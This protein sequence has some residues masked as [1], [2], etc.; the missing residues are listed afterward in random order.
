MGRETKQIRVVTRKHRLGLLG[1]H[2]RIDA[3]PNRDF[4]KDHH[5]DLDVVERR[6]TSRCREISSEN[7]FGFDVNFPAV[8]FLRIGLQHREPLHRGV[9]AKDHLARL[10]DRGLRLELELLFVDFH[11]PTVR[12]QVDVGRDGLEPDRLVTCNLREDR[13]RVHQSESEQRRRHGYDSQSWTKR[14]EWW[15]T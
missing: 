4:G 6:R 3:V 7:R 12:L 9:V 8:G 11:V 15:P 5:D 14:S 1:P 10:L 2:T 13:S